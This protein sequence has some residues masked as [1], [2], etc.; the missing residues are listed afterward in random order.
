[1]QIIGAPA[2]FPTVWGWIKRWFDPV[3]VSKIFIL[4]KQEVR[5]TLEKFMHPKDFPKRYGGELDWDWGHL[6]HLDD[7]TRE[8]L[9]RDGNKGW[10]PGPQLWL[11][12]QR[13][14]VGKEKG[15]LRRNPADIEKMKPVV[16]AADGTDEPVHPGSGKGSFENE[17][18]KEKVQAA[19]GSPIAPATTQVKDTAPSASPPPPS[20]SE[21]PA[22][23]TSSNIDPSNIRHAPID[24]AP[25]HLPTHQPGFPEQ[26]AEYISQ[27]NLTQPNGSADQSAT[28]ST[29]EPTPS[30]A[31]PAAPTPVPAA[32]PAPKSEPPSLINGTHPPAVPA[33]PAPGP[34][35]THETEVTKAIASKLE[36]ESVSILPASSAVNGDIPHP[37]VLVTSDRSKGIAVEAE[38]VEGLAVGAGGEGRP[39]VERF[40]TATEIPAEGKA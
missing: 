12:N 8:A 37:E 6:P 24:G 16:Y 36:G 10:V 5:P 26:V 1:V 33:V 25:V 4:S 17:P 30:T 23:T 39:G 15:K 34:K 31:S 38:K 9:E 2:F 18:P 32:A 27:D 29:S 14:V 13:V 3:T 21:A 7:E 35:S 40:V 22:P 20:T 11:N 28:E 19:N